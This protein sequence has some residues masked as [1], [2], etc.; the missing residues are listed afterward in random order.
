MAR[1][2]KIIPKTQTKTTNLAGGA[3]YTQS[4]DMELL[5]ILLTS[6]GNDQYYRK[7]KDTVDRLK[8]LISLVDKKFVAQAAVYA[9]TVHG[10]RTITH[11]AASELAKYTAE[12]E[13]GANF[14]NKIINRVDDMTE[15]ASYHQQNNGKLSSMMKKGFAKAFDKF[16]GY[17]L[18]KYRAEKK[19][20]KLI[21]IVN[22]VHPKATSLNEK[23]LKDLGAGKLKIT[24]ETGETWESLLSAAG[25][26]PKNKAAAWHKL[27]TEKTI[28]YLGLLRNL[29][30]IA[31]Q[32]PDV[33]P[34][35]LNSL[36]NE[37]FIKKSLIFPFQYLVAY[38]QFSQEDTKEAR[39]ITQALTTAVDIS[40]INVKELNFSGNTL[41][42]IDNSGS[43]ASG[44][45]GSTY[46]EKSELGA[47]F[48]IVMA[49]A[50]NGDIMEFGDTARYIH[51]SLGTHSLDFAEGFS[52]KNQVGHGT[53]FHSVLKLANKKYDRIL[54]FSDMQ[55][56]AGG[57][58]TPLSDLV[59]YRNKFQADP[60]IYS[61]DLAGYGTTQFKGNKIYNL[62]GYS[63]KVLNTMKFFE[64]DKNALI[65]EVKKIEL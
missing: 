55:G 36:T 25:N 58:F 9:R 7:N 61:F 47:L 39:L 11:I 65:N 18:A 35:A 54:F 32:A 5:S 64:T 23:A 57:H 44:V 6:F 60:Y 26:D 49:R 3:A 50:A 8:V 1:F 10:M 27:I 30:N 28:G 40:C 59:N 16:T 52:R 53:D 51:Y 17:H 20:I 63:D 62:A 45:T 42:A 14:F 13:W 34:E 38:K 37:S 22:M 24:E 56:W 29:S 41:V 43:M 4:N 48:G 21:D 33:L 31:R 15:I 46:V 19:T 12:R 2:N